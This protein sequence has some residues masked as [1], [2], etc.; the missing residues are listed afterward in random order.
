[1]SWTSQRW[2]LIWQALKDVILTGTGVALILS[3]VWSRTPSDVL[4]VTGLALTVPSMAGHAKT[5]LN[6]GSTGREPP[7]SPSTPPSGSSSSGSS[8]GGTDEQP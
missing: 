6:A 7:S 8:S 5:L 4:L 3:Q 1:M 2:E